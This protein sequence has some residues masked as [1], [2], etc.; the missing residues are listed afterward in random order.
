MIHIFII[1]VEFT[2]YAELGLWAVL[3]DIFQLF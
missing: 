2:G 3:Q 1:F